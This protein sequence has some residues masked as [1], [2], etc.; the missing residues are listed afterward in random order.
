MKRF[1]A[2]ALVFM[3]LLFMTT[4]YGAAP[5]SSADPLISLSYINNTFL[6]ATE[7]EAKTLAANAIG[8]LYDDAGKTLKS[9]YDGYLAQ[10]G[11]LSGYKLAA[12]FTPIS[13]PA[14]ATATLVTGST[15]MLTSGAASVTVKSGTVINIS[16]GAE[17]KSGAALALSQKY[18]CAEDTT[19]V[20]TATAAAVA[21]VDGYYTTTGSVIASSLPFLDVGSGDWYFSAVSYVTGKSLFTGTSQI[22]FSPET[23]MTRGMFVTVLHRLAGKPAVSGA[24]VFADA[25]DTT[26]YYYNAVIWANAKSIVTGY[27]DGKFH[28]DDAITREQMAAIICRYA[29]FA[30]YG[31][32]PAG[33]GAYDGFPDKGSVSDYAA[34]AMKWATGAGLING[35]DGRLAPQSTASRAQVAQIVLNFCQKIMGL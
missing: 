2:G 12:A 5:G 29:A 10:L 30:G 27:S 19:A 15:L 34:D 7:S 17:V 13:L 21:Q 1:V 33:T 22:T 6:P 3:L 18:F 4:A 28:P 32:T 9:A 11:G 25:A 16:T 26:Q 24:S 23:S 20:F 35:A 31:T 8:G 14:G